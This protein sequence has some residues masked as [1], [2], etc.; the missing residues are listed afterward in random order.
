[1]K[2]AA[3]TFV[4]EDSFYI[5]K[6]GLVLLGKVNG[7]VESGYQLVFGN[8]TCWN[9]QGVEA[10]NQRNEYEKMGLLVDAPP[11]TNDELLRIIWSGIAQIFAP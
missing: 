7:Q 10:I 2:E 8:G 9:I 4:V 6:R 11:T 5:T 3:G 1:M